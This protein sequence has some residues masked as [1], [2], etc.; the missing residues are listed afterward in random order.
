[1]TYYGGDFCE[2]L[3]GALLPPHEINDV[4]SLALRH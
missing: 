4:A 2:A 3:L 1:M